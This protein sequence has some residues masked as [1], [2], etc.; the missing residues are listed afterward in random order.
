MSCLSVSVKGD[1]AAMSEE[2]KPAEQLDAAQTE[3]ELARKRNAF[4]RYM[5]IVF[6]VAFLLV[7][8][9]LV[10]Q[11]HTAKAAM[12]DLKESNSSALTNAAAN[13]ELLQD[14]NRKLQEQVDALTAELAEADEA[15]SAQAERIAALEKELAEARDSGSELSEEKL[16]RAETIQAYDALLTAL[17]CTTREGNVT[18]SKAIGTVE[19]YKDRLSEAALAVYE[20]LLEE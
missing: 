4:L 1:P 18:F 7:L 10:L 17:R 2:K 8:V 6:A 16:A 11:M 20:G 9:S 15:R 12:S 14:D 19:S 5:T 13:A 3:Q